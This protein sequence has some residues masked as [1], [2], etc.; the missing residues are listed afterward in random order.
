MPQPRLPSPPFLLISISISIL[1]TLTTPAPPPP[2][3]HNPARIQCDPSTPRPTTPS[4]HT[5]DLFLALLS[6]KAHQEPPGAFK[7]Y[8][9]HMGSCPLCV[10]LPVIMHFG[11]NRE[12]AAL[13]AVDEEDAG[14]F[15]VFGLMDLWRALRDVVGV[16]WVGEGRNGRGYPGGMTAWAGFVNGGNGTRGVEKKSRGGGEGG[17]VMV[18]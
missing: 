18:L 16:C 17:N 13:I 5:C 1:L 14:E 10:N 11:G 8:G 12:C 4:L 9:R 6:Q 7:Y 2:R 3:I 15:S